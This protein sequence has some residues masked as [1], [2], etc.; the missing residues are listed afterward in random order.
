M[1]G[2]KGYICR[3]VAKDDWEMLC[4]NL[5]RVNDQ[6]LSRWL[7]GG[8]TPWGF[9]DAQRNAVLTRQDAYRDWFRNDLK[10][11]DL[12]LDPNLHPHLGYRQA[13]RLP[14]FPFDVHV[15]GLDSAWLAGDDHDA[16][17]RQVIEDHKA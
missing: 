5:H 9:Q 14:G 4:A 2:R 10:Q 8:A 7:A 11:P 15:I 17:K 6:D 13:V 12:L 16:G 3:T 1:L